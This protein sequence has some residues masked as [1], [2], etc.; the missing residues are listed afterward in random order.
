MKARV[1]THEGYA[2]NTTKNDCFW[3][4][5]Q[6]KSVTL[7]FDESK[8]RFL[9]MLDAQQSFLT[10]KQQI[11]QSVDEYAECLIGWAETIETH[12]GKVAANHELIPA[13]DRAGSTRSTETRKHLARERTLAMAMI[14]S[15]DA[16]RYG[17]LI[18]DLANQYASGRDEY[19]NSVIAAKSLLVMYRTPVN[20]PTNRAG[21]ATRSQPAASPE[22]TATTFVQ[23][24]TL[25]AGKNP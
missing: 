14:R 3:L 5:R 4:L 19:P 23:R 12:G 20:A 1:K 22:A 24:N 8:D 18:T 21:N 9:S 13:T 6:I 15:A 10:C 7:Q 25:T 16:S 17:T 2:E 11:G